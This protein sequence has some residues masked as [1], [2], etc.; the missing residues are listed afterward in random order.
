MHSP[1]KSAGWEYILNLLLGILSKDHLQYQRIGDGVDVDWILL[2]GLLKRSLCLL[3]PAK[4]Q[5]RYGLCN[6]GLN[7]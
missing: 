7:G 2:C 5:L 4:V 1:T 6:K 3:G